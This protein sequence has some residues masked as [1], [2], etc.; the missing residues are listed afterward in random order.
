M[1]YFNVFSFCLVFFIFIFIKLL[2]NNKT[3]TLREIRYIQ[4]LEVHK[5]IVK[6]KIF[7]DKKECIEGNKRNFQ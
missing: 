1:V 7:P 2:N 6:R 5:R 3:T 4:I